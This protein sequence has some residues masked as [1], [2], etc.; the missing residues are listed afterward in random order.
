MVFPFSFSSR[1][2]LIAAAPSPITRAKIGSP[3]LEMI[4]VGGAIV[5]FALLCQDFDHQ[6]E[7]FKRLLLPGAQLLVAASAD[8]YV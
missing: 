8:C 5:E 2:I 6:V 1:L 4:Y 7:G 3:T